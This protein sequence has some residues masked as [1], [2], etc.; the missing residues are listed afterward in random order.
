MPEHPVALITGGTRGI[1]L[2]IA[3]RLAQEGYAL[4]L[5][6]WRHHGQ[7]RTAEEQL[8]QTVPVSVIRADVRDPEAVADAARH[9]STRYGPIT[10]AVHNAASGVARPLLDTRWR[11]FEF[12]MAVNA[13]GFVT[14]AQAAVPFM[15]EGGHLM[16]I[17]SLGAAR[18]YPDYGLVGASKAALESLAR[19]FARELGPENIR[20][21]VIAAGPMESEALH[22]FTD[23]PD[24][25]E[26]FQRR[27]PLH[28]PL[29]PADVAE[30]VWC[31]AQQPMVTG[32]VFTVDGGYSAMA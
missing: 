25:L 29:R 20:V 32:Q 18:S 4:G 1:G 14:L 19:Q 3:Q 27:A 8:S 12:T 24:W 21:N 22:H 16:A 5:L 10:L 28:Q 31:L 17:S 15:S 6:Y 23:G 7:A 11:H 30:A 26:T 9:V 2:A 13:W